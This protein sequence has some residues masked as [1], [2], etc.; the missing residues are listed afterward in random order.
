MDPQTFQDEAGDSS[1]DGMEFPL[2]RLTAI[3]GEEHAQDCPAL[4]Q[5]V[6]AD[7]AYS[8]RNRDLPIGVLMGGESFWYISLLSF[9][10]L[11]IS[12]LSNEA[13]EREAAAVDA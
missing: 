2:E 13:F 5:L 3:V 4:L 12:E 6:I 9:S 10:L 11:L 7:Y 1:E 8:D